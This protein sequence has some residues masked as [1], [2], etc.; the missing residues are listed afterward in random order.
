MENGAEPLFCSINSAKLSR[1]VDNPLTN[2]ITF[3]P[4]GGNVQVGIGRRPEG[5]VVTVEDNGI[6]IPEALKPHHLEPFSSS[7]RTGTV[8]ERSS[9]IGL[10]ISKKLI[11][12]YSGKIWFESED[13]KGSTFFLLL[14]N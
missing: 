6:G 5:I 11:E 1:V 3:T 13:G 4:E 2:A 9:G 12:L 8:G 14:P 7:G 10:S